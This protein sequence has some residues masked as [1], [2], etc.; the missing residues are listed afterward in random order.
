MQTR[1]KVIGSKDPLLRLTHAWPFPAPYRQLHPD[2]DQDTLD[3][4]REQLAAAPGRARLAEDILDTL[5]AERDRL[6]RIT[7]DT[8]C[9]WVRGFG[10]I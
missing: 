10:T 3:A 4:L 6:P 1:P 2:E 5:V 7:I 8:L 9:T